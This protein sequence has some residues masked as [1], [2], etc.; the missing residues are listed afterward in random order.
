MTKKIDSWLH[1]MLRV[2]IYLRSVEYDRNKSHKVQKR[3]MEFERCIHDQIA[4]PQTRFACLRP[5]LNYIFQY[6]YT[7]V[8]RY[9]YIYTYE[10]SV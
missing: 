9:L 7:Y 5:R 1:G 6:Q 2:L 8:R 10:K 3:L 4:Q